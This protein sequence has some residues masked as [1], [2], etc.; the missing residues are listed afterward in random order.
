MVKNLYGMSILELGVEGAPMLR[1]DRIPGVSNL[2]NLL[3]VTVMV[4]ATVV[5]AV[6]CVWLIAW[7]I[8]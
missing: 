4:V 5:L 7:V 1:I 2:V 6:G 8:S 3:V